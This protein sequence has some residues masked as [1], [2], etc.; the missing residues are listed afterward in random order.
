MS[1]TTEIIDKYRSKKL[2]ELL[3]I[4][5][6][7]VNKYVRLRDSEDGYFKCVSCDRVL[8]VSSMNAG[9]YF[10]VGHFQ[11]VR[12]NLDNIHGQCEQC[13]C[14]KSGNLAPYTFNLKRKIGGQR[15][16]ELEKARM[17]GFKWD[18]L[19]VILIIE[20]FKDFK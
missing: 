12:Y 15:F 10:P 14:Y 4:A 8:P 20:K 11:S 19:L 1:L 3:E 7:R 17:Q 13:N 9:H 6:K 5:Q 16:E 2:S 18:R